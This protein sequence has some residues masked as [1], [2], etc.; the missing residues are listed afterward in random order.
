MKLTQNIPFWHPD[1][2][3]DDLALLIVADLA[4][5]LKLG[6]GDAG[7]MG[8]HQQQGEPIL[9]RPIPCPGGANKPVGDVGVGDEELGA[10]DNII[11]PVGGC[12]GGDSCRLIP[13]T[14]LGERQRE[15]K[16][17]PGYPGEQLLLLL[18]AATLEDGMSAQDHCCQVGAGEDGP[19]H[20]IVEDGH[21]QPVA[22]GAAIILG[23]AEPQ[24]TQ[25][26]DLAPQRWGEALLAL[27]QLPDQGGGAL[28]GHK[29]AGHGPE[30]HLFLAEIKIH[31]SLL[32][33]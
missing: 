15:E 20:F 4:Y 8:V 25:L 21:I 7:G 30:H 12:P 33:V 23:E 13:G 31:H 9:R 16:L 14:G 6:A 1:P 24:P 18:L 28:P 11:F 19:A 10:I 2:V 22:T 17:P 5:G 27:L 3:K 29:I 32:A 26:G